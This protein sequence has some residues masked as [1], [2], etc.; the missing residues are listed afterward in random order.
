MYLLTFGICRYCLQAAQDPESFAGRVLTRS[1]S[2]GRG[3]RLPR[4]PALYQ[5]KKGWRLPDQG[6]PSGY[7]EDETVGFPC[8]DIITHRFRSMRPGSSM[9]ST[10]KATVVKQRPRLQFPGS[11]RC[12]TGGSTQRR[13]QRG[14]SAHECCS[15]GR[16]ADR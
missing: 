7:L 9:C 12:V 8:G 2:L 10:I 4:L 6:D 13:T 1:A 16:T 5:K 15:T 3:F 14:L 11:R